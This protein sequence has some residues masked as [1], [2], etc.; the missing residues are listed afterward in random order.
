M[1]N[2]I[3]CI[4]LFLFFLISGCIIILDL[5]YFSNITFATLNVHTGG[6][7]L[8][9]CRQTASCCL[10]SL[11]FLL[12][13]RILHWF[14]IGFRSVYYGYYFLLSTSRIAKDSRYF[15]S[16]SENFVLPCTKNY[17]YSTLTAEGTVL[18]LMT[19]QKMNRIK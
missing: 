5:F 8:A 4:Y 16:P 11:S 14:L 3:R 17:R 12:E 7:S 2:N 13:L 10:P 19:L 18:L 15:F 9:I 1:Y 6:I